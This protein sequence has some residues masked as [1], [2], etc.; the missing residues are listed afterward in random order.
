[1]IKIMD[2][3]LMAKLTKIAII[4]II[5]AVVAVAGV[6]GF[7]LWP[8]E[9]YDLSYNL[10]PG[11]TYVYK[12]IKTQEIVGQKV[13]TK[14]KEKV[15]ILEVKANEVTMRWDT[16]RQTSRPPQT[17]T[18][19]WLQTITNKGE[20]RSWE[21]ESVEPRELKQKLEP[22]IKQNLERLP[23]AFPSKPVP[24][25]GNW[26]APIEFEVKLQQVCF[27]FTG[28]VKKKLEG[29]ER[30]EVPAG[31]F[32]CFKLTSKIHILGEG[33]AEV[34]IGEGQTV[35]IELLVNSVE[36]VNR[37]SGAIIKSEVYEEDETK[38]GT[39]LT[40]KTSSAEIKKLIEYRS[41]ESG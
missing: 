14:I 28:E 26:R 6:V 23:A 13:E 3:N 1:V 9:V 32:D 2:L 29:K 4:G 19:V 33:V 34:F 18:V 10:K 16:I 17:V 22:Q 15:D 38:M 21:I 8:P 30:I 36:W 31:E 35:T 11:E 27:N 12:T 7:L 24:V 37:E 5:V 20:L 25:G 40:F 39:S 41:S